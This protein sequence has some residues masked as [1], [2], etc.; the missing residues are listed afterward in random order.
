MR[1]V[2]AFPTDAND[3]AVNESAAA[4]LKS[5]QSRGEAELAIANA[6]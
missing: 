3:E 5:L 6:L 2:L 4:L 1:K